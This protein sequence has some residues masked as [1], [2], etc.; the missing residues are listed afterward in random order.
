MK[1]VEW[2]E[3]L[4]CVRMIDQRILPGELKIISLDS[5]QQVADAISD[6]VV[7][8]APA[9]GVAAAYGLALA[10]NH[11]KGAQPDE[12]LVDLDHAA[13]VLHDARPTASNLG[14]ALKRV[15]HAARTTAGSAA[16]MRKVILAEA[17]Q[18]AHEDVVINMTMARLGADVIQDGDT[19]IHHCNTGCL[20]YTSPSPRD[21]Q[22]S[23]MPSSA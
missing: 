19:I 14:W 23:R 5:Y 6:M 17:Q 18:I 21:R 4:G 9:I 20:L 22:K 8:G 13:Q 7:R 16:E 10:A 15:L 11:S 12:L 3:K 2:D 1:T